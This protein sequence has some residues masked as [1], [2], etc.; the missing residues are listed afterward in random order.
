[1]ETTRTQGIL[2]EIISP[3]GPEGELD[4]YEDNGEYKAFGKT[5]KPW[6]GEPMLDFISRDGNHVSFTYSHLYSVSFN[7]SKGISIEFT[8]H[9][10]S[11]EGRG[12]REIYQY[13]GMQ[14]IVYIAEADRPTAMQLQSQ[15]VPVVNNL[16]ITERHLSS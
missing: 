10:V 3:Q 9:S 13:L 12:L 16:S 6:G 11:V 2:H 14:R 15:Q 5:R 8:N 4:I 7:P 1:M